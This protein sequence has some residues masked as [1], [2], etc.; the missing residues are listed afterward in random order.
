MYFII[1]SWWWTGKV[2]NYNLNV[3]EIL[4]SDFKNA[5]P[6]IF[7]F[8]V[9]ILDSREGDE[10]SNPIFSSRVYSHPYIKI[11]LYCVTPQEILRTLKSF[12]GWLV[13]LQRTALK[14]DAFSDVQS[15]GFHQSTTHL[16]YLHW[17]TYQKSGG[18][19]HFVVKTHTVWLIRDESYR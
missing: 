3:T 11:W 5:F 19:G 17:V 8:T 15:H 7:N 13:V 14:I 10:L 12:P 6:G 16:E 9:G 18:S 2:K 4:D 1:F